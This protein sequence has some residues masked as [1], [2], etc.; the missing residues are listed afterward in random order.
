MNKVYLIGNLTKDVD[1]AETPSCVNVARFTLAVSR[2][3]TN[4]DGNR[5]T[6]FHNCIAWRN[7]GELIANYCKKGD[8][9]AI[10]GSLQNRSYEDK[11]GNKRYVTDVV[12]NEVEFLTPKKTDERKG[13]ET[14]LEP[15]PKDEQIGLPF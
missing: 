6:D 5:D 3:Y 12:V 10:V 14:E 9:L 2:P 13:K 1:L 7:T 4:A 15:I 8:K 11:D